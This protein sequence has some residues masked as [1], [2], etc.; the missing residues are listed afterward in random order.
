MTLQCKRQ[1]QN[2]PTIWGLGCQPNWGIRAIRDR[3]LPHSRFVTRKFS[4]RSAKFFIDG[5][6]WA[7][8]GD[9]RPANINQIGYYL[10][11]RVWHVSEMGRNVLP[12][13][14]LEIEQQGWHFQRFP[15]VSQCGKFIRK[16]NMSRVLFQKV[17]SAMDFLCFINK[18]AKHQFLITEFS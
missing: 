6:E 7:M 11:R 9:N 17:L 15:D 18:L 3:S 14:H 8:A 4:L 13:G 12:F 1:E 16:L 2:F 5:L 10:I